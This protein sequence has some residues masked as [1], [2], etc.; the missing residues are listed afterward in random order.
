MAKN[1]TKEHVKGLYNT[2]LQGWQPLPLVLLLPPPLPPPLRMEGQEG[3][4]AR[5]Y[6]CG[7]CYVCVHV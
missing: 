6:V 3:R 1:V 4:R 7:A 5:V 2:H